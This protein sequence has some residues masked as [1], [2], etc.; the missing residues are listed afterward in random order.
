MTYGIISDLHCHDWS[1]F[2]TVNS[3]GVNSRLRHI[4]DEVERA[5]DEVSKAGGDFLVIAGDIFHVRGS[6]D[7]EVLNPVRE[8]FERV[9]AAGVT[10][11]ALPGNHDLK[12]RETRSLSSAIENLMGQRPEYGSEFLVF[13]KVNWTTYADGVLGFVPWT[14]SRDRLHEGLTELAQLPNKSQMDVFIHAGID[15]VL[16]GVPAHGLT[17]S[18][19]V[20]YGFRRVFA[21][22]YH[23]H[24]DMGSGV[25]SVGAVTHQTW[26]DV[27]TRA[28][29]LLADAT[30]VT[31]HDTRAPKFVDVSALDPDEMEMESAGNY[32]RFRGPEMTQDEI[33]ELRQQFRDWGASGVAVDVPKKVANVRSAA[34]ASGR[35]VEQSVEVFVDGCTTM[36]ASVDKNA[37]KQRAA[38]VLA[39][40]KTEAAA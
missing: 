39:A 24:A 25:Y 36:P 34:P 11:M 21:G 16:S 28:G 19:L 37:V 8:T 30:S 10:V 32:V 14:E 29:F 22:H 23:N 12:S 2:S 17:A 9:M 26:G 18:D 35:S 13:N 38:E 3:D 20:T 27:G 6:I 15:G 40:A 7:P 31:F 5:A 33:N 4:L 1:I